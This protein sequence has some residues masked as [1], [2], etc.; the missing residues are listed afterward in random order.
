MSSVI[1][2]LDIK[3]LWVI[4]MFF[5]HFALLGEQVDEILLPFNNKNT[6]L[7]LCQALL[8][9]DKADFMW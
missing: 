2:W 8:F 6:S 4:R 3:S 7:D 5:T 1:V 9:F